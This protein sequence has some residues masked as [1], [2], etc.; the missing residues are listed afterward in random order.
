M[1]VSSEFSAGVAYLWAEGPFVC[2]ARPGGLGNE[3][4][5]F[6]R[7]NGLNNCLTTKFAVEMGRAVGPMLSYHPDPALQPLQAG[8]GKPLALRAPKRP[9]FACSTS[10]G[11]TGGGSDIFCRGYISRPPRPPA[12]SLAGAIQI[13]VGP[14]RHTRKL[15]PGGD[16]TDRSCRFA[17]R[18]F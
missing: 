3:R 7:A 4:N 14:C 18:R 2:L 17:V 5:M 13:S 10:L 9:S 15:T 12:P 16:G 11:H 6:A 1:N 8:L